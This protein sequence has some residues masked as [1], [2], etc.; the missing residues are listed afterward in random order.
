M[1]TTSRTASNIDRGRG[2][3]LG[4]APAQAPA[5]A[6]APAPAPEHARPKARALA[7]SALLAV[8]L[9]ALGGC[10]LFAAATLITQGQG[11]VKG[12][13]ELNPEAKTVILIDDPASEIPRTRLRVAIAQTAQQ[14]LLDRK[15]IK[16]G[17]MLDT[18]GATSLA[19]RSSYSEK[20]SVTEIGEQV[21]ADIVVDVVV[22]EFNVLGGA[23]GLETRPTAAMRMRVVDVAEQRV[24]W[25]TDNPRGYPF[26]VGVQITGNMRPTDRRAM[27]EAERAL[28]QRAGVALAQLFY[29]V[30]RQFSARR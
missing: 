29:D 2:S 5:P 11:Q 21:G 28:A 18:T 10:N 27:Q 4:P 26:N 22:T 30:E 6:T 17:F 16:E 12:V 19:A 25:P 1:S 9:V 7:C 15:V 13:Y 3:G 14:L 20:L 23:A 24:I 8:S